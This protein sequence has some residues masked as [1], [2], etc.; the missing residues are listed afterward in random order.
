V[1]RISPGEAHAKMSEGWVY[2][3]VRTEPEFEQ[4]H[5]AGAVNIPISHAGPGG[6]TPNPDFVALTI[7]RFGKDAKLVVGC[8]SGNRSL[9]AAH[10]LL[11]AGFTNVLDQRAGWDGARD[12]FGQVTEPGW[13]RAG[14]PIE[15]GPT[16]GNCYADV[17]TSAGR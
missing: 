10:A 11:A 9:R 14:L 15:T 5:P 6:M 1:I 2:L 7:A 17:K 13:L 12:P 16:P 8:K 4:G 3:D